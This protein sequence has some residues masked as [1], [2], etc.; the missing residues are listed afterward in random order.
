[1]ITTVATPA[2]SLLTRL[3]N[4]EEGE[5]PSLLGCV[6]LDLQARLGDTLIP[7]TRTHRRLRKRPLKRNRTSGHGGLCD[8][9]L[10]IITCLLLSSTL[11]VLYMF[12]YLSCIL[13]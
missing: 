13:K 4:V 5:F 9:E 2:P 11:H 1:M 10:Y 8:D 12:V 6:G 7:A 3:G